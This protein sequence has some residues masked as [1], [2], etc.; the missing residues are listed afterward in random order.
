VALA[1]AQR[2]DIPYE[3][4]EQWLERLPERLRALANVILGGK[5][6]AGDVAYA[7][8]ALIEV[9]HHKSHTRRY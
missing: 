6:N 1:H 9:G 2:Q 7:M 5:M 3:T 4:G 8:A